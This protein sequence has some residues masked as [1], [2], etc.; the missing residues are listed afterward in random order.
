MI[1]DN[2]QEQ[3]SIEQFK[4]RYSYL[5]H[6]L[7]IPNSLLLR[8]QTLSHTRSL[9]NQ[10]STLVFSHHTIDLY[11][12]EFVKHIT[13]EYLPLLC[14]TTR[15]SPHLVNYDEYYYTDTEEV[16]TFM[17]TCHSDSKFVNSVINCANGTI[18]CKTVEEI[19]LEK[20]TLNELID[21]VDVMKIIEHV[22]LGL[23]VLHTNNLTHK[24][25]LPKNILQF[26]S[27]SSV[28][29]VNY[30]IG[31]EKIVDMITYSELYLAPEVLNQGLFSYSSDIYAMGV[32]ALKMMTLRDI[33]AG[34]SDFDPDAIRLEIE[35]LHNLDE[36]PMKD[37]VMMVID[38]LLL[39]VSQDDMFRPNLDDILSTVSVYLL[40]IEPVITIPAREMRRGPPPSPPMQ[41]VTKAPSV[42]LE[43]TETIRVPPS[44]YEKKKSL[45]KITKRI[46]AGSQGNCLLVSRDDR[47]FVMKRYEESQYDAFLTEVTALENLKHHRIVGM[48]DKFVEVDSVCG[49]PFCYMIMEPYCDNGDLAKYL[50]LKFRNKFLPETRIVTM[51]TQILEAL[52]YIHQRGYGHFDLKP[53]NIYVNKELNVVLGDFGFSGKFNELVKGG[54]PTYFPPEILLDQIGGDKLDIWSLGTI[55]MELFTRKKRDVKL[56]MHRNSEWLD[57]VWV[58]E[59]QQYSITFLNIIKVWTAISI[60]FNYLLIVFTLYNYI[61]IVVK[62]DLLD[63]DPNRRPSAA[64]TLTMFQIVQS[65]A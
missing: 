63:P 16:R 1:E 8:S 49:Q 29:L 50:S 54:S 31:F 11:D 57:H 17:I 48:V 58:H 21:L 47:I 59:C 46:G 40:S 26:Q 5:T 10:S 41:P 33:N 22:C 52:S 44:L 38:L 60:L 36:N 3:H 39:C 6:P 30:G 53:A 13:N 24:N 56:E 61:K 62:Q 20:I 34:S 4:N 14:Q 35:T 51:I 65:N 27:D 64:E 42:E 23:Q 2:N 12:D 25:L 18:D 37:I 28:K 55:C 9:L 43:V 32:I 7:K 15:K 45:Y 19:I